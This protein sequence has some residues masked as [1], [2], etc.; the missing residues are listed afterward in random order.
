M[1]IELYIENRAVDIN[2]S[3]STLLT[4][5]I[6]DISDFG[7]KNTTYSK[8]IVLPGTKNNNKLFGNIFEV[9]AANS[10]D[11]TS[12]NIGLNFNAA[13]S[14]SAYI[15][16]DNMQV[17]KGVFRILEIVIDNGFIEYEC[18]VFGELGGFISKL[19]NKKLEDLDFSAYNHAWTTANMISSWSATFGSGYYYPLIDYGNTSTAKHDW[20]FSTL[21]PALFVKQYIDKIFAAA[22]YT[23][24]CTH[25]DSTAFKRLIVPVNTKVLY[26]TSNVGIDASITSTK[27]PIGGGTLV[28]RLFFDLVTVSNFTASLSNSLFTFNG[29]TTTQFSPNITL[30][31]EVRDTTANTTISIRKNGSAFYSLII[32]ASGVGGTIPVRFFYTTAFNVTTSDTIDIYCSAPSGTAPV[33]SLDYAV[34]TLTSATAQI[35][36]ANYGDTLTMNATIP[37]GILQRDFISSIVKMYNLYIFEDYENEYNLKIQPFVD[38]YN[39]ANTVDWSLKV[40]R[41]QVMKLKP[42]SELN[43]RYF[44]FN[45]KDDSDFYNQE[46]KKR[47]NQ[48]YGSYVYDSEYEFANDSK[49]VDIIFSGTPV[50]GYSGEDKLY[51]TIFK[52][53]GT[54]EEQIDSNIRILQARRIV[55]V[56]SWAIKIGT[57]TLASTTEY[58]YAGHFDHPTIP[59]SDIN[60]GVSKEL[61]FTISGGTLTNNL[62]NIYWS[63]Y[64][65]EITDK[66]S[67][68]LTCTMKLNY[69]DIYQLDFSK[70][71]WVDGALYRINKIEDFNATNEDI[72]KV[73]LLKVI[74][75]IY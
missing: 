36:S 37:K 25:F 41:S 29:S 75:R 13:I 59:T 42:M 16:A 63:S 65:A 1:A 58:G 35:A 68:L 20:E 74:N 32:P 12:T 66:D 10:Y 73:S 40:D 54:T 30:I 26:K 57:T 11:P 38:F 19:G 33:L 53:S 72:C 6:D 62:F 27:T 43:A 15:F 71:I 64:M 56:T 45:Y 4:M 47:Y 7:S 52:K 44:E 24:T 39:G 28:S 70:L 18:A 31:G 8:T 67:R 2:E 9:T 21:R 5:S 60:F 48:T 23:Y 3:F 55:G 22:D 14:A 17:F 69:K 34:M 51:P 49:K 50:V 61:Y 46:Y